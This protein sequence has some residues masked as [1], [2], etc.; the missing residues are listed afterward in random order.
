MIGALFAVICY[1]GTIKEAWLWNMGS[2]VGDRFLG[3]MVLP[4]LR[5]NTGARYLPLILL[6]S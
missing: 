6:L 3:L 2:T 4:E 5:G 1:A